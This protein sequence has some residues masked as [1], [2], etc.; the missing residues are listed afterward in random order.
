MKS[1]VQSYDLRDCEEYYGILELEKVLRENQNEEDVTDQLNE[2][3]RKTHTMHTMIKRQ[4]GGNSVKRK[5][6]VL[7]DSMDEAEEEDA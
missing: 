3:L 4:G 6:L 7:D 5:Q 2:N 1:K